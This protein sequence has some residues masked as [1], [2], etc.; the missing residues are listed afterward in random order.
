MSTKKICENCKK[1]YDYADSSYK[2][3]FLCPK[4]YKEIIEQ[5]MEMNDSLDEMDGGVM[6]GY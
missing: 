5:A 2:N 1:E 6:K 3:D 4:C